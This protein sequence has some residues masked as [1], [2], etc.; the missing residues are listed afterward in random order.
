MDYSKFKNRN[1]I[2]HQRLALTEVGNVLI[3]VKFKDNLKLLNEVA[4]A[5]SKKIILRFRL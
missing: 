1:I 4:S 3:Y 2:E 5:D